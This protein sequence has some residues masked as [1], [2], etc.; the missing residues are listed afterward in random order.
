MPGLA[1][2]DPKKQTNV[3][4]D[5]SSYGLGVVLLQ[6]AVSGNLVSVAFASRTLFDSEKR[7]AQ[8]EKEGLAIAWACNRSLNYLI[9]LKF[10]IE[11]DHKPLLPILT[12]KFLDEL[13][14]RLQRIRLRMLRFNYSMI[15]TAGK[16][17]VTADFLSRKPVSKPSK[18]DQKFEVQLQTVVIHAVT[19]MNCSQLMM[20]QI[21][22]AQKEIEIGKQLLRDGPT[23][24]CICSMVEWWLEREQ[25]T[26]LS[27]HL[28]PT[29]RHLFKEFRS[30]KEQT[31]IER[32]E[33]SSGGFPCLKIMI[34]S[35]VFWTLGT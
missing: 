24:R 12:T 1:I 29:E 32:Y 10:I 9:G 6:K 30:N 20:E 8:I 5:A 7:C 19:N 15:H 23:T 17:W 26:L 18:E 25:I 3:S 31:A 33:G 28:Y 22:V 13:T 21:K 35:A 27:D 2:Y 11:T 4:C 14:P 34:I 16:N